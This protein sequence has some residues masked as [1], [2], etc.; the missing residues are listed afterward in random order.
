MAAP[1][2]EIEENDYTSLSIYPNPVKDLLNLEWDAQ[3]VMNPQIDIYDLT[4]N[5]LMTKNVTSNL[6]VETINIAHL[7]NGTFVLV[8]SSEFAKLTT[9]LFVKM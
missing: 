4:G 2:V 5:L 9:K 8:F 1:I 3:L 6:G 7:E